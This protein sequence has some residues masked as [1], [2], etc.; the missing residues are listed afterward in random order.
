MFFMKKDVY[1]KIGLVFFI[2]L[3]FLLLPYQVFADTWEYYTYGG[4]NAVVDAWRK[5]GL[6]F[7]D[8]AF[9]GLYFSAIVLGTVVLYFMVLAR[10]TFA[11]AARFNLASWAIPVLL[12]A[13]IYV[14]FIVP[15]DQIVVYDTVLNRGPET[16]SNIPK[17]MAMTAGLLNK[18][19][20]GMIDIVRVSSSPVED[21]AQN[22]GGTGFVILSQFG[23]PMTISMAGVPMYVHQTAY[24]FIKDCLVFELGR[25]GTNLTAQDINSGKVDFVTAIKAAENPGVPTVYYDENGKEIDTNQN[26]NPITCQDVGEILITYIN[27][28]INAI[29]ASTCAMSGYNI[30]VPQEWNACRNLVES[31]YVNGLSGATGGSGNL[32]LLAAQ[33]FFANSLIQ[34]LNSINPESSIKLMAT[35]EA[36]SQYLGLAIHA[37]TWLPVIKETLRTVAIA[38]SPFVLLFA[39]TPLAARALSFLLG[40]MIWVVT[41]S[42]IDAILHYSAVSQAIAASKEFTNVI[43]NGTPG[44]MFFILL[45][46]YSA[47]VAAV[48]GAIRW[49]GLGL[50]TVLTGILIKFGGAALAMVAGSITGTAQSAGAAMG[51]MVTDITSP[52][53]ADLLPTV[54]WTN[55]AFEAGGVSALTSGLIEQQAGTLAG[56]SRA[57]S[58]L[59]AG[60]IEKS[61]FLSNVETVSR[62]VALGSPEIAEKAGTIAGRQLVGSTKEILEDM[63]KYGS[64]LPE[65]MGRA[66]A[67][68]KVGG[69]TLGAEDLVKEY[70]IPGE[71]I[72]RERERGAQYFHGIFQDPLVGIAR[73]SEG[74]RVYKV[75]TSLLSANVK[76][77]EEQS[78]QKLDERLQEGLKKMSFD[79]L[80][81]FYDENKHVFSKEHREALENLLKTI[82][83]KSVVEEHS[84]LEEAYEKNYGGYGGTVGGSVGIPKGL[85]KFSASASAQTG[86]ESAETFRTVDVMRNVTKDDLIKALSKAITDSVSNQDS[87]AIGKTFEKVFRNQEEF[88]E[89]MKAAEQY[90]EAKSLETAISVNALPVVIQRLGD[91]LY[92]QHDVIGLDNRY[93]MAVRDLIQA[94][95]SGNTEEIK[96]FTQEF[97]KV[98]KEYVTKVVNGVFPDLSKGIKVK[99]DVN[100]ELNKE[101]Q[102]LYTQRPRPGTAKGW[103]WEGPVV[104]RDAEKISQN[105]PKPK[106]PR[107][108]KR[109]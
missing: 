62:N 47:K 37:N 86:R 76:Q 58:Y 57:G 85:D 25:S 5:V 16:I 81:R 99:A 13:S 10:A 52:I 102:D 42:V 40:M 68:R 66:E 23:D 41:W 11:G 71:Q 78:L 82:K 7:S 33:A 1:R 12:G 34:T 61:T 6:I 45:P 70:G 59:G 74:Y 30:D 22:A 67:W 88:R 100:A 83:E 73:T 91:R 89:A 3:I 60:R 27:N 9:K 36:G 107:A 28:N 106:G 39:A 96:K 43:T 98:Q 49:A 109:G 108:R 90:K 103:E 31:T 95:H 72:F 55:A 4:Y 77:M 15:K 19:E 69:G 80:R 8:N 53:K 56:Q 101:F 84:H 18:I 51:R 93:S 65:R 14:A 50:A 75:D 92:S 54:S 104:E 97:E 64:D 24:Q 105:L 35:K 48:F 94:V 79:E 2:I 63:V 46:S 26:G 21:Y 29:V 44:T 32:N 20:K 17:I 38:I 87:H